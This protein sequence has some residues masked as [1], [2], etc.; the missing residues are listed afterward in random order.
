MCI[1]TKFT[2][3]LFIFFLWITAYLLVGVVNFTL[4]GSSCSHELFSLYAVQNESDDDNSNVTSFHWAPAGDDSFRFLQNTYDC[5]ENLN[6]HVSQALN[7][8]LRFCNETDIEVALYPQ[9]VLPNG[10]NMYVFSWW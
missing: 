2:R 6:G 1:K 4:G 3:M 7:H 8:S 5:N 9:S 10:T